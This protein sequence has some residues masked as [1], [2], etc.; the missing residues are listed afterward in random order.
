MWKKSSSKAHSLIFFRKSRYKANKEC[1]RHLNTK[2]AGTSCVSYSNL[3][4]E[5]NPLVLV[6]NLPRCCAAATKYSFV[7]WTLHMSSA[8]SLQE[9]IG[10][11]T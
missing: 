2:Q 1:E 4:E 9:V 7:C 8:D 5:D 11:V 6:D 10:K 3:G